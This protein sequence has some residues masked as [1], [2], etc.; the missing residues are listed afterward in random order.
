MNSN[1]PFLTR[2]PTFTLI[3]VTVPPVTKLALAVLAL[4]TVPS[5][6]TDWVTVPCCTAT[7]RVAAAA[8]VPDVGPFTVS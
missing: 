5:A 3:A 7:V 8:A 6:E 4:S 2:S 1:W